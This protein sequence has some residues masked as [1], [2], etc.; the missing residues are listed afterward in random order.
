MHTTLK[1]CLIIAATVSV[2]APS[3]DARAGAADPSAARALYLRALGAMSDL[4]QPAYVTFRLEGRSQGLEGDLVAQAACL[5]VSFGNKADQ[6]TLRHRTSDDETEILDSADHHRYVT[7]DPPFDPTWEGS[8]RVL[9][10]PLIDSGCNAGLPQAPPPAPM[11]DASTPPPDASLRT[12]ATVT[13]LG[14]GIYN[15]DDRGSATCS[16]GDAGRALHLWSRTK[17]PSHQLSDVI[18][19]L[20][21]MRFCMVRLGRP[22][23][24]GLGVDQ[25]WEVHY[26]DA[27]GHWMIADGL[28]EVTVR[29]LGIAAG[30]G[31][32]RFHLLDMQ[33]PNSLPPDTFETPAT[34]TDARKGNPQ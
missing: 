21:S 9:S 25:I 4:K 22:A 20:Q 29:A 33:F 28:V 1:Y 12:I 15:I 11:A 31:I 27:A 14:P 30:R 23:G 6:W 32:W 8:Y 5:R 24:A 2:L 7:K 3:A 18:I 13:A 26:G 16:N 19:D 17:N 34:P 10:R